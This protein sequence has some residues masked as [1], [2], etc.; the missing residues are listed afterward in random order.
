MD[1]S[2][3]RELVREE[4]AERDARSV[5]AIHEA[6]DKAFGPE[7]E[8]KLLPAWVS[9][10]ARKAWGVMRGSPARQIDTTR[11][12]SHMPTCAETTAAASCRCRTTRHVAT[13]DLTS[14]AP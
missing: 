8:P 13:D 14:S 12:C 3:I 11:I 6:I 7:P 4:F 5:A 9:A 10:A 1:E 2:R